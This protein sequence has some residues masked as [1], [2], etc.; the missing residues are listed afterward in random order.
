MLRSRATACKAHVLRYT[1]GLQV[2][3]TR[4]ATTVF[5][6][7]RLY[8]AEITNAAAAFAIRPWPKA[9]SLSIV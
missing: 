4:A 7:V 3:V 5:D 2:S 6:V 8:T 1:A 9:A